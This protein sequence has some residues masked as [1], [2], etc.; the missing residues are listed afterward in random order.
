MEY[1]VNTILKTD[2]TSAFQL[3][4]IDSSCYVGYA[5]NDYKPH[6]R[7]LSNV[8]KERKSYDSFVNFELQYNPYPSPHFTC[9][10]GNGKEAVEIVV[11]FPNYNIKGYWSEAALRFCYKNSCLIRLQ[12]SKRVSVISEYQYES[13]PQ[14]IIDGYLE[15]TKF[16][17]I[18]YID[19]L[20]LVIHPSAFEI[21]Q[22]VKYK[23]HSIF[24]LLE[25]YIQE[26]SE[27]QLFVIQ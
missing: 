23:G 9:D 15:N 7:V 6:I 19:Y 26:D 21:N 22:G 20:K 13:F 3:E 11:Q 8:V 16:L 18:D 17:F 25:D 1:S 4:N 2:G 27:D 12:S 14:S 5:V 24:P 10:L